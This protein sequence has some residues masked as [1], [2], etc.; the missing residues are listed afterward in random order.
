MY[1]EDYIKKSIYEYPSLYKCNTYED[2]RIRV[3]SHIFFSNGNGLDFAHTKDKAKGGYVVDDARYHT[4]HG[5]H[6]RTFDQPYGKV[7]FDV[8]LVD[9][10]Y[11]LDKIFYISIGFEQRDAYVSH[12]AVMKESYSRKVR[13][14]IRVTGLAEPEQEEGD[15]DNAEYRRLRRRLMQDVSLTE[16]KCDS[17][18]SPSFSEGYNML[19]KVWK[20]ENFLQHDWMDGAIELVKRTLEFFKDPEQV[21]KHHYFPKESD[22]NRDKKTF[23]ERLEK[24]GQSGVDKLRKIWGYEE[25]ETI[26]EHKNRQWKDIEKRSVEFLEKFLKVYG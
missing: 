9:D 2:S 25:G 20:G 12:V 26:E 24:E 4:R 17:D 22:V 5:D 19:E 1:L 23:D 3:L 6:I 8:N 21:V 14:N 13:A 16:S 10:Q 18:F 11:F 7:K 15:D